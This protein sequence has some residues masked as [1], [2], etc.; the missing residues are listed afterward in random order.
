MIASVATAGAIAGSLIAA[1]MA[2][3]T[4]V[5]RIDNA[6]QMA[7]DATDMAKLNSA[8]ISILERRL[9]ADLT[10]IKTNLT[11]IMGTLQKK[12]AD[13]GKSVEFVTK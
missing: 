4:A 11:W 7:Q 9:D 1:T 12:S 6:R 3:A 13:V 5:N 10:E 8:R 2:W